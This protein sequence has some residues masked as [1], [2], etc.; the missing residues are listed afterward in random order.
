[1]NFNKNVLNLM[2]SID[3]V[4]FVF[5][6]I[7]IASLKCYLIQWNVQNYIVIE[8]GCDQNSDQALNFVKLIY[9]PL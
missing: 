1:M 3:C 9:N 8:L 5:N 7:L 4:V 2:F 6:H